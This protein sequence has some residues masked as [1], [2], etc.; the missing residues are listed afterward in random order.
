MSGL[1]PDTQE[2]LIDVGF[3]LPDYIVIERLQAGWAAIRRNPNLAYAAIRRYG[4]DFVRDQ[5][6]AFLRQ[7]A[8]PIFEG[9]PMEEA[10]VPGIG[11][12]LTAANEDQS[13][14]GV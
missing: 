6:F 10:Q 3:P 14:E 7:R 2:G 9:W 13:I 1:V 5:G 8:M 11:I 4:Q 12:T